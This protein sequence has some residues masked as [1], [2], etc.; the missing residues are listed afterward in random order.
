MPRDAVDV[1]GGNRVVGVVLQERERARGQLVAAHQAVQAEPH[2]RCDLSP[3]PG[4]HRGEGRADGHGAR[5]VRDGDYRTTA[6]GGG[7]RRERRLHGGVHPQGEAHVRGPRRRA[8]TAAS[9]NA[10]SARLPGPP[11]GVRG[12]AGHAP[13]EALRRGAGPPLPQESS[14]AGSP[15][16]AGAGVSVAHHAPSPRNRAWSSHAGRPVTTT[17]CLTPSPRSPAAGRTPRAR[18]RRP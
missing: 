6:R 14:C 12:P 10:P 16:T 5:A 2:D 18:A 4:T 8:S 9:A 7:T 13:G 11:A 15:D 17:P 1:S 3:E